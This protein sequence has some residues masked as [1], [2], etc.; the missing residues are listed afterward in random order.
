MLRISLM[1]RRLDALRFLTSHNLAQLKSLVPRP[2]PTNPRTTRPTS[3]LDIPPSNHQSPAAT[4]HINTISA[5]PKPD[6]HA[7]ASQAVDILEEISA[8]LNCHMDRRML[9]TCISLIEQGVHPESLVVRHVSS[10]M[11]SLCSW[12]RL[13]A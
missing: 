4:T 3:T 13:F 9:S 8:M 7:A 11:V 1:S 10:S 5:M 2:S 6:K 12:H